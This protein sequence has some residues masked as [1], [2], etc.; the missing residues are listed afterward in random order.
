MTFKISNNS[1]CDFIWGLRLA[2]QYKCLITIVS[3]MFFIVWTALLALM[4][5][6]ISLTCYKDITNSF[7]NHEFNELSYIEMNIENSQMLLEETYKDQV[8]LMGRMFENLARVAV[9][10]DF[11]NSGIDISSISDENIEK[12]YEKYLKELSP[13]LNSQFLFSTKA[14]QI[15]STFIGCHFKIGSDNICRDISNPTSKLPEQTSKDVLAYLQTQTIK[16]VGKTGRLHSVFPKSIEAF[17][18]YY[19][20]PVFDELHESQEAQTIPFEN[21]NIVSYCILPVENKGPI[22]SANYLTEEGFYAFFMIEK[23]DTNELIYDSIIE[24]IPSVNILKTDYLYPYR[25]HSKEYCIL[26]RMITS[27][28][29]DETEIEGYDKFKYLD[30][31]F[32]NT[33]Y[34]EKYSGTGYEDHTFL[35]DFLY[36]FHLFSRPLIENTTS[37]EN[38]VVDLLQATEE[39]ILMQNETLFNQTINLLVSINNSDFKVKKAYSPLYAFYQVDYFYPFSDYSMNFLIKSQSFRTFISNEVRDIMSLNLINCLIYIF[40]V[41]ILSFIALRCTL[42]QFTK[43]IEKAIN[44]FKFLKGFSTDSTQSNQKLT[45]E[46]G[47]SDIDEFRDLIHTFNEMIKGDIDL[48]QGFIEKE[49]IKYKL[50]ME[51]FNREFEHV[52]IHNIIVKEEEI[53][54]FLEEGNCTTEITRISLDDIKKD[55][56]VK[57][58]SVFKSMINYI[59]KNKK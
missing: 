53:E 24:S 22:Y 31:C 43:Q 57:K 6:L 39:H 50:D 56:F 37:N 52:K 41:M 46:D 38:G 10:Q 29:Q 26:L 58:S 17:D 2:P 11:I 47:E 54:E 42:S 25:L 51:Q 13:I 28:T 34:I 45:N 33:N 35:Y 59:E 20:L 8:L 9:Y 12:I 40:F 3:M 7:D 15:D 16:A 44:I 5:F 55:P 30:H 4:I 18:S 48:K 36:N 32:D 14:K 1:F 27:T 19:T 23:K 21:T 49:A